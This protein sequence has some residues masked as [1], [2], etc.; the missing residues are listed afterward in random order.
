MTRSL[1]VDLDG[2]QGE[3]WI[4]GSM[5]AVGCI[6]IT[7]DYLQI[8]LDGVIQAPRTFRRKLLNG[9]TSTE[10]S[11]NPKDVVSDYSPISIFGKL[12]DGT[13][14]T[15][16]DARV[17]DDFNTLDRQSFK[18]TQVLVGVHA[19]PDDTPFRVVR[20]SIPA[21]RYW[22]GLGSVDDAELS[23]QGL[24]GKLTATFDERVGWLEF[25][26]E[27]GDGLSI[28]ELDR[29]FWNRFLTLLRLWADCDIED[30][31]RVQLRTAPDDVW[32]EL[33][34]LSPQIRDADFQ[35]HKSLLDPK[36]LSLSLAAKALSMFD[37]LAPIPDIAV[38]NTVYSM[39]IESALLM[40][41]SSLEGLHHRR[42]EKSKPFP[43]VSN[44][45]AE[46]IALRAA[47]TAAVEALELKAIGA[48]QRILFVEHVADKFKFF[49]AKTFE[50]RL[51]ELL[52][53][54]EIAAPGLTGED[55]VSWI[56]AVVEA[57]NL[58]AHRFPKGF[59]NYQRRTDHYYQLAMS[60]GW[61]LK[62]GLLLELGVSPS[63]LRARLKEHQTFLYALA[64][65]DNCRFSW[66]GSRFETFMGSKP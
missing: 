30:K 47:Q 65:M 66:P 32:V 13:L 26:A 22:S 16:L 56:R 29:R 59:S 41:A 51:E 20:V 31:N 58:E 6:V 7:G 9:W 36:S 63:L 35:P 37:N 54:I 28:R 64:N 33:F 2:R 49:N 39:T 42:Y 21:A 61:A 57:R 52:P 34:R 10:I 3:F 17:D 44:S 5:S 4:P 18:A 53:R 62:I 1:P 14:I 38:K 19:F 11:G 46:K 15:L 55:P 48:E 12:T 8:D 25:A 23:M 40:N 43:T 27:D 60:T 45:K 50:Q 24:R